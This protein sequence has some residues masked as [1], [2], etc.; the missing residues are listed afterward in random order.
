MRFSILYLITCLLLVSCNQSDPKNN[1]PLLNGY[2][3]IKK[4]QTTQGTQKEYNFSQTIDYIAITNTKG[5]RKKVQPRL[6]GTFI[7]SD[8]AAPF[9][10][11]IEQDSLRLYYTT[12]IDT[13]KETIIS[14]K[15]DE[16]IVRNQTGNL[17]FYT[18][19][20]KISITNGETTQ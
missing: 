13:W 3:Q 6:D 18:P 19:Y 17:Y 16:M 1:I 20:Q 11:K 2:W 5:I 4:V 8:H 15:E 14:L 10:I 7:S 12:S 9:E